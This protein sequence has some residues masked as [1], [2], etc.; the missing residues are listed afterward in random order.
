VGTIRRLFKKVQF[1]EEQ[2]MIMRILLKYFI[3]NE[4]MVCN[5]TSKKAKKEVV[6]CNMKSLR[7]IIGDILA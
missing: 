5:L 4:A 1:I 7:L 3:Q 2:T 6:R